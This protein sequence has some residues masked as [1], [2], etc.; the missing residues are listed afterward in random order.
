LGEVVAIDGGG[1]EKFT[2]DRRGEIEGSFAVLVG[3]GLEGFLRKRG[4]QGER[5]GLIGDT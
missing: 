3:L 4:G 2:D 5:N 1:D